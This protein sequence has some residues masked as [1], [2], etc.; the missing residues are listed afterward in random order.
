MRDRH[1]VKHPF[2]NW[3]MAVKEQLNDLQLTQVWLADKL[4]VSREYVTKVLKG[5]N[6]V[7]DS[8]RAKIE[9]VL[10]AERIRRLDDTTSNAQTTA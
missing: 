6:Y 4:G 2:T 3:G 1:I 5:M 7:S 9:A 10:E 8:R